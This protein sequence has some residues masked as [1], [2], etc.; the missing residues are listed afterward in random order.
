MEFPTYQF[1]Q[2]ILPLGWQDSRGWG[3][4][5]LDATS[6]GFSKGES[7]HIHLCFPFPSDS[8]TWIIQRLIRWFA[9]R[10]IIFGWLWIECQALKL[11]EPKS[12]SWSVVPPGILVIRGYRRKKWCI[13]PHAQRTSDR[14]EKAHEGL[15][16][17]TALCPLRD[18]GVRIISDCLCS[19]SKFTQ[20]PL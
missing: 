1:N 17:G 10:L 13:A 18:R 2:F 3:L 20:I 12:S 14:R 19:P 16:D 6:Y 9:T 5:I 15:L 4:T 7:N 8:T 11:N